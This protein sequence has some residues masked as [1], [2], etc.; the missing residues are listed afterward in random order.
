M[1][2]GVNAL[3]S[4]T[5]GG[6]NTASG[7]FALASNITG[8][9]NTASGLD[10]LSQNTTGNFN[11]AVGS[12]AGINATG[13]NN[14]YVGAFVEGVAGESNTMYL[15]PQDTQT[16]TVIAG[17]RGIQTGGAGVPVVIDAN[18]QLGTISSSV[19]F[20][21]DIRDMGE[22]SR[23]LFG[24]RPVT[25]RYTAAYRDGTKP[26]QYG[27]IAEEVATAFPDLAVRDADGRVETVHYETLSVLLLNEM[28]LQQTEMQRQRTE[29]Q[30]QQTEMQQHQTEMQ[31]QAQRI[32]AL[33]QRLEQAL[34]KLK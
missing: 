28:Q 33:A 29:I 25:F 24:L 27:L 8:F 10:A 5:T 7:Y 21:E 9:E 34:A 6:A 12:L 26:L 15:G 17:I 19:R 18:G 32:E 31:Q 2:S 1:A 16:K 13:S 23:A 4:N 30:K 14:I 3:Q 22:A 11:V 20:K